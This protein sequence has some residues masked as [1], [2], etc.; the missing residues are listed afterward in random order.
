MLVVQTATYNEA[1]TIQPLLEQ[2]RS[3][4]PQAH[5]LII[6][7]NSPD[8]TGKIISQFSRNDNATHLVERIGRRGL[9]SAILDGIKNSISLGADIV[10]YMDADLSHNPHDIP[11]LLQ[12]LDPSPKTQFDIAIG[13]RRVPGGH[14]TGWSW[15]RHVASF[16]VNWFTYFIL[17]VPARDA[18]SGFRAIRL[19][20]IHDMDFNDIAEGYAFQEDFLWRAQRVGARITEVP[21]T[22][23]NRHIGKSKVNTKEMVWSA[24]TLLKIAR[25]TWLGF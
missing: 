14:I 20:S 11:L 15:Q 4:V 25:R 7:D 9:G 8:G 22:F 6:D 23:T 2:I 24:L 19:R 18:S 21:I 10:V 16:L 5:I 13:S 3:V 12:A 17:R 1:D